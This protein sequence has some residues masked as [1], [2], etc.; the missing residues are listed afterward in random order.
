[1]GETSQT[2]A[3]LAAARDCAK[4]G[5][6]GHALRRYRKLDELLSSGRATLPEA[7]S[8]A[9]LPPLPSSHLWTTGTNAA[10]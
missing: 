5:L 3:L 10:E 6:D 4:D 1:M 8:R 2:D 9:P 7:W